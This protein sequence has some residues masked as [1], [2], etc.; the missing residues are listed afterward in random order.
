MKNTIVC[1]YWQGD[2]WNEGNTHVPQDKSFQRHLQRSGS[3]TRELAVKYINNLYEG[4]WK[5]TTI[6]FDFVCFT[7]EELPGIYEGIQLRPFKLLTS[8][9]VLP[10]MYMFS[11]FSGLFGQ[12]VLSLDLDVLITGSLDSILNY[13]GTFCT[14]KSWTRGEETLIDGDIMSFTAGKMNESLFWKPLEE[15]IKKVE[16]ISGGGRER[17]WVRY[18]MRNWEVDTWQDI[19][20]GQVLSYKHHVKGQKDVPTNARIVSCHGHP[21]PHQITDK[22]RMEYWK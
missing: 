18:V 12:Q 13:R 14:R 1:F 11:E 4:C 6:D 5:W 19:L 9:G 8:K 21:R 2:R 20:P 15:D 17:F 22:W 16:D 3:M 7:N 10:R